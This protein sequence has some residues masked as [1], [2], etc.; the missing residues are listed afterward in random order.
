[1]GPVV[2]AGKR[3]GPRIEIVVVGVE[4]K[5]GREK[6]RRVAAWVR[7]WVAGRAQSTA[8]PAVCVVAAVRRQ[9]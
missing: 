9:A 4:V 8:A 1:M 3:K 5:R 7:V 6:P 2:L